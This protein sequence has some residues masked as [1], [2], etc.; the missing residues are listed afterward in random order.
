MLEVT[1]KNNSNQK[2][3]FETGKCYLMNSSVKLNKNS[4]INPILIYSKNINIP[5]IL[6]ISMF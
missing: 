5:E 6:M 1:K 3:N 2:Y 4:K